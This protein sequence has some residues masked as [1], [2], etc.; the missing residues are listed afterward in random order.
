MNVNTARKSNI[1][2]L[3]FIA[4]LL[5]VGNHYAGHGIMYKW[6]P[7]AMYQIWSLGS[8]SNKILSCILSG[9][10]EIG[11]GIFFIITGYFYS[12][13]RTIKLRRFFQ[14]IIFYGVFTSVIGLIL[15]FAG[16][17]NL[18]FSTILKTIAIPVTGGSWWFV[19]TYF[20]LLLMV[21]T[22]NNYLSKIENSKKLVKVLVIVFV[23]LFWF[24]LGK[25]AMFAELE[26][27]IF[28]Y[29]IGYYFRKFDLKIPRY[30]CLYLLA[31]SAFVGVLV[32]F[33]DISSY[34]LNGANFKY[35]LGELLISSVTVPICAVCLFGIFERLNIGSVS[36]INKIS[37]TTFGIYLL[38][39]STAGRQLFWYTLF[40]VDSFQYFNSW[41]PVLAI[42]TIIAVFAICSIIDLV[43][44]KYVEPMQDKV[45]FKIKNFCRL[46]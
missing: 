36:W 46:D 11:V 41:F 12:E 4:M 39:D 38:H 6:D 45:F 30:R 7:S 35:T 40:K 24:V 27:A 13:S 43:R 34:V 37:K 15:I 10:G 22:I 32:R 26:K 31:I 44:I 42:A 28:F 8:V 29:T 33:S 5:I 18:S 9:G 20:F 25:Y 3:R 19:T 2:L 17:D 16:N 14:Q 21:P 23:W 1:E